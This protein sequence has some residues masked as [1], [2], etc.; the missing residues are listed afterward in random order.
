M[1]DQDIHLGANSISLVDGHAGTTITFV[2]ANR[3]VVFSR[4]CMR[5][6][7]P[8]FPFGKKRYSET[9]S[10]DRYPVPPEID[11]E[12][13]LRKYVAAQWPMYFGQFI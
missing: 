11:S 1:L 5:E 2:A 6:K 9:S 13:A 7:K 12:E 3:E 8:F 4:W 10:E